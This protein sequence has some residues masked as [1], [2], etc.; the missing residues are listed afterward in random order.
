MKHVQMTGVFLLFLLILTGC[1]QKNQ[2]KSSLSPFQQRL[3]SG[4]VLQDS[5]KVKASGL[6]IST[7]DF[8]PQKWYSA[9]VPTTVMAALV[10]NGVYKNIYYGKNLAAIPTK[11]FQH[12]W[13]FRKEF[14]PASQAAGRHV[15]LRFNGIVYRAN[16]FLNGQKIASA[17]TTEGVYRRFEFDVTK[18]I[19][20][21]KKNVL[22]VQVFPP[23]PGEPSL[24]FVDWNPKPPD[25]NLGLW[26]PVE[27]RFSQ[28][29]RLRYPHV[30][31]KLNL[32]R[33]DRARLT[34]SVEARNLSDQS[35][36]GRLLAA[37]D[38]STVWQNVTLAPHETR[39]LVF[40][41]EKYRELRV[42]NPRLWWPN[43]TGPQNLHSLTF[44]FRTDNGV[45]D[46]ISTRFGIREVGSYF[47][48]QGGRVFTVNGK[49][50]LIRG[51][52]WTDDLLLAD[53]PQKLEAKVRYAKEMNLNAIR[54]EGI[55]GTDALYNLCD[56]YGLLMLVG[57]S[58]QWE[59]KNLIG[60]AC[61]QFGGI[62][63]PHQMDV[64]ARSWR[65]QIL[66]LR[67]HPSILVWLYGSDKPPRPALE[68]R[69]QAILKQYDPTRPFLSSAAQT[70]TS[71]TGNTGVKM[72]GPY[73]WVPPVYW[74]A[75]TSRGGAFG[76]STEVGPGP[77]VPPLESVKRMIP[78]DHLWPIDDMWDFHCGRG[79]F[80]NLKV[81]TQAISRRY[82][83]ARNAADYCEKAQ[84]INYEGIRAMYEAYARNKYVSTGV[85]Q[86]MLNSAW[87]SMIWQLYDYYLMPGGAYFGAQKACEP[88]HIQYSYD[89]HSVVV[90]N[91]TYTPIENLTATARVFTDRLH[92]KFQRSVK[93][94]LTS[95]VSQ[96]L[97]SIPEITGLSTLYFLD[98]RLTKASGE[99]VSRNFYWLSTQP[100]VLDESKAT[101]Y[102]TPAAAFSDFTRL[103]DLPGV[104]LQ[105]KVS[106]SRTGTTETATVRVK[107]PTD[108][109]A[110]FVELHI[111]KGKTGESVLP[112]YWS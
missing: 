110:F 87:P 91:G 74:Y 72:S 95:N 67:N 62:Q 65:D 9:R 47:N 45:S 78:P 48:K 104:H 109:L 46:R 69:Y 75:D 73:E 5:A 94:S 60:S 98:L 2:P 51:G 10:A 111:E 21:Q 61:D 101:W 13:W 4:W 14:V 38:G 42:K 43:Q 56:E 84:L 52:G 105:T 55:W 112:I 99:T 89:D 76:F 100:D 68:K 103:A 32:P 37:F 15:F 66:R 83:P 82:G 70:P 54:V 53:S 39:E 63:S 34:F 22:A 85:I 7:P 26:Q 59:W 18:T 27:L 31:T 24:G 77:E 96:R 30:V 41:P 57:W 29:V 19:H 102:V 16:V 1:G 92:E 28:A 33:T 40:T 6:E 97:F 90:V 88:V 79:K 80:T 17:D 12:S 108:K 20:P 3:N 81:Y 58:C 50:I 44:T 64:V 107:N 86:W 23:R 106:F 36:S 11:P 25:R 8:H 71:V 35:V 49:P 93:V